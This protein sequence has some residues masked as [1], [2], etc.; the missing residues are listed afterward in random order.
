MSE[1]GR[2]TVYLH[3]GA[4][5]T[6]T[7]YLQ[8]V[9]FQNRA[10][11]RRNGLLYP[12]GTPRAHFLASQDLRGWRFQGYEDP[13]MAGAWNRLVGQAREWSGR[14]LI[15]HESFGSATP[16]H[17]ERAINDLSFA[18]VHLIFTAR[19][20][21]RQLPAAW[22]ERVRNRSTTTF[23]EF[24]AEIRQ[25]PRP[26]PARRF[27]DLHG[28]DRILA[29]W[30]PKIPPERVH[31][32]TVPPPGS[33]PALL[34]QRFAEV[35]GIDPGVYDTRV[36]PGAN[37]SLGA[38]EVAVLRRLNELIADAD[39]P[40]P[41]YSETVKRGLAPR[42]GVRKGERIAL[43]EE[44]YEW[45]VDWSHRTVDVLRQAGYHVVGDLGDLIPS[46]RPTGLD[47][48]AVPGDL[49]TEVAVAGMSTV[50]TM[51][52]KERDRHAP[53]ASS[54]T[55]ADR[56]R[57]RVTAAAQQVDWPEFVR[58]GYRKVQA[59]RPSR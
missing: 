49:Q 33:D 53:E 13:R 22:Q 48:D 19:D 29:K 39:I 35:L 16:A 23:T 11:L 8:Q 55:A 46:A 43:P 9:V 28:I 24:L 37:S 7:T 52:M 6:G 25:H 56:A 12:G 27:W 41:L 21:A 42:L 45:A 40:W 58:R 57:A 26:G 32:V 18:N 5:K 44:A 51:L 54:E 31:I 30:S 50:M 1:P 38:A 59:R 17:V 4:P 47:P 34:W 14:T 2:P 20:M 36:K 3:I 15:S 10:A